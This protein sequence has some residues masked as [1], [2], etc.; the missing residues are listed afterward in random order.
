MKDSQLRNSFKELEEACA[1]GDKVE[2]GSAL[3]RFRDQWCLETGQ[4]MQDF[5]TRL[6]FKTDYTVRNLGHGKS[7]IRCLARKLLTIKRLISFPEVS[8]VEEKDDTP[9]LAEF[10]RLLERALKKQIS[11]SCF[12]S[13]EAIRKALY[14]IQ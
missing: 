9:S 7:D 8:N 6:G 2:A 3:R 4:T 14:G 10:V 13:C 12:E 11:F 1:R 5:A